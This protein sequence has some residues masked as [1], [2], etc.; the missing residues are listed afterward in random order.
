MTMTKIQA[1]RM[2]IVTMMVETSETLWTLTMMP[3][4]SFLQAHETLR[5]Y[6]HCSSLNL[7]ATVPRMRLP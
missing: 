7:I 3:R 5:R 4:I 2:L 6:C 1:K